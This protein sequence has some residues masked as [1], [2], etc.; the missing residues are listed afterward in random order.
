MCFY[1]SFP[2]NFVI[3]QIYFTF[4]I[5]VC[6]L[7]I[8]VI[9]ISQSSNIQEKVKEL[10]LFFYTQWQ[11]KPYEI[12]FLSTLDNHHH[13]HHHPHIHKYH[14]PDYPHRPI[15]NMYIIHFI[16]LLF[17]SILQSFISVLWNNQPFFY[18]YYQF[19]NQPITN[20]VIFELM[21]WFFL[22][23]TSTITF[24]MA[25]TNKYSTYNPLFYN[26][27]TVLVLFIFVVI[28]FE[29][30]FCLFVCFE[31]ICLF[32]NDQTLLFTNLLHTDTYLMNLFIINTWKKGKQNEALKENENW[33]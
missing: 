33:N 23:L 1:R 19:L 3:F 27:F 32:V 11:L 25:W 12:G 26:C 29:C 13:Y 10:I 9:H 14:Q 4:F 31:I 15:P 7:F 22:E 30:F 28:C 17:R 21:T 24:F 5:F 16:L 18:Y 8:F 2:W 6:I 20:G